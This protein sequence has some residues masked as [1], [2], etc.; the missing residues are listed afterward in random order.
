MKIHDV[1]YKFPWGL[2]FLCFVLISAGCL[3]VSANAGSLLS[4]LIFGRDAFY[5]TPSLL[6]VQGISIT[7]GFLL[8]ALW[9]ARMKQA[10]RTDY[11]QCR[12]VVSFRPLLLAIAGY[13]LLSPFIAVVQEWNAAWHFPASWN[14]IEMYFRNKTAFSEQIS[15]QMLHVQ[16]S[17]LF[18]CAFIVVAVGA[19]VC[20]EFFFRGGLQNLVREKVRNTHAA[21]W[22][23]AAIFSFFHIDLFGF[24]PR[25]FLGA[26]LGYLYVWSESIWLPV[27]VHTLN[28]GI[29]ALLH[30]LYFNGRISLDPQ[31]LEQ[32]P[33]W[34]YVALSM[35]GFIVICFA[36]GKIKRW[37]TEQ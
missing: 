4:V 27:L 17:G 32:A 35:I 21:I 2:Q 33:G 7:G 25:L 31:N 19:G 22:I 14:G 10:A 16:S 26:L 24:F 12:N 15:R 6:V 34:P 1:F 9:L 18:I 29:L 20:E 3:I 11:L 23:T 37:Q 30:F 13:L 36:A 28:N 5:Q 8:P